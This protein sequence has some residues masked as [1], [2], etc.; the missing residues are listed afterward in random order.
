VVLVVAWGEEAAVSSIPWFAQAG[1]R[2]MGWMD[3]PGLRTIIGLHAVGLLG[4][5]VAGLGPWRGRRLTACLALASVSAAWLLW[6][7]FAFT[8]FAWIARDGPRVLL[9]IVTLDV[10]F[11]YALGQARSEVG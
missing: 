6:H 10:V 7:I 1:W 11:A 8:Q 9:S 2:V 4:P 5:L 3:S